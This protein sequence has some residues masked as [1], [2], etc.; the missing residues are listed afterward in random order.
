VE[1]QHPQKTKRSRREELLGQLELELR[2][3]GPVH[4]GIYRVKLEHLG[5][6]PEEAEAFL[7]RERG[8]RLALSL[9]VDEMKSPQ[10]LPK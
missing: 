3:I 8:G 1:K 4:T 7:D 5:E 6:T 2:Q 10:T 9:E